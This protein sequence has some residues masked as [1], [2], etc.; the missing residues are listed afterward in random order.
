[1]K[2][3]LVMAALSVLSTS[4]F[5][6]TSGTLLLRGTVPLNLSLAVTAEAGASTLDL[7]ATTSDL[8]VATIN[9]KSNSKTGYKITVSSVNAGKL[10]RTDGTEVF[11]YTLKYGGSSVALASA[12][13]VVVSNTAGVANTNKDVTISYSG[14]AADTMVEGAYE[15]TLSFTI[16]AN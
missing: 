11:S 14:A 12:T 16:A 10:K 15:D 13:D 9:E 5:S 3:I 2:K 6:A 4:A 8:K 1:M 7:T